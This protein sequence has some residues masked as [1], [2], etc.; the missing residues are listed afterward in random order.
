MKKVIRAIDLT[1]QI[2]G[3]LTVIKKAPK[4]PLNR[5]ARWMCVCS[6]GAKTVV[7]SDR[8]RSGGTKSCGCLS[9]DTAIRIH[10]THGHASGGKLSR[11]YTAWVNVKKR[12][13]DQN[14]RH[15]KNYGGRGIKVCDEWIKSF[16][17]FYA[18][19]GSSPGKGYELDR[20]DNDGNYE[21]GNCRWVTKAENNENKRNLGS[22]Q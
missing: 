9:R 21:P 5:S 11:E 2:F 22:K 20:R 13:T 1:G 6:C 15:W 4:K 17:A 14:T 19:V 7:R 18:D 10:T 3:R 8:L 12:C 16:E